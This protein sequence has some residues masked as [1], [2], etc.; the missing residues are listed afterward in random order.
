[1]NKS[2]L[3]LATAL[4]LAGSFSAVADT[5]DDAMAAA[6]KAPRNV[7]L[8]HA[9][10]EALR[11]AGRL[12]ESIPFYLK[13]G[14]T[15][16]LSAAEAAFYLYRF[17]EAREYLDKYHEKLSKA[18]AEKEPRIP[19]AGHDGESLSLS[20]YLSARIDLGRSML[21]RV[22]KIQVIDSI[23][24]PAERLFEFIRLARDAGS[25]LG[26]EATAIVAND[27]VLNSL[28]L[29]YLD[30]P[31]Y[32]TERG[33]ELYWTGINDNGRMSIYESSRLSDGFWD[34]PR[35]LFDFNSIFGNSSGMS[36]TSPFLMAD[37]VTLYFAAD[38]EDSLGGLDIFI[39]RRDGDGDF[40]QPSNIGMPY[41]SP[42]N[43][44]MYAI[45]ETTGVGWW[46]SDRS[47]LS[48]SVTIYMFIPQELR[49]NYD[50]DTPG[51]ADYA[52]LTSIALTQPAGADYTAL[53]RRLQSLAEPIAGNWG[54]GST[55]FDFALPDGRVAHRLSDFRSSMAREAMSRLLKA[56]EDMARETSEL[57]ALRERYGKGDRSVASEIRRRENRLEQAR[58]DLREL[59]NQVA[60]SEQ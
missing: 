6:R 33:D 9:A 54:S 26:E 19:D 41:N 23:N 10:A 16:Y 8:N 28:G 48:D 35:K 42:A 60:V 21:D 51:L 7:A 39:S 52:A 5:V 20:E 45:D 12:S 38:G 55:D 25:L 37:G 46:A 34:K 31:S 15:G 3:T 49:I 22:E 59:S 40:L 1:M 11:E 24:V 13:S 29:V 30:A 58:I 4:L 44:Y 53:R 18:D 17:D 32:L 2:F 14:N 57:Q 27:D 43:D 56:R 50:V 47:G 36:V